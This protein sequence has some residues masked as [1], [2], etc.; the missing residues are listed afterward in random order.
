MKHKYSTISFVCTALAVP[1]AMLVG[2]T[3]GLI[4]KSSNP[5]NVDITAGLAYLTQGLVAG[6]ATLAI[7]ALSGV[8]FGVL[9][10]KTEY[11]KIAKASLTTLAL[12]I[13]AAVGTGLVQKRT[14]TVEANY[15]KQ[16]VQDLFK[17]FR[18]KK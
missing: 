12:V 6:Y 14:D 10:L 9:G 3:T 8:V 13:L 2:L 17:Q 7:F 18:L 4:L 5:S 16:Q 1:M 15:S 11:R